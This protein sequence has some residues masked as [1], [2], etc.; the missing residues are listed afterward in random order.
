MHYCVCK[1][2][3]SLSYPRVQKLFR[4]SSVIT[5]SI[6]FTTTWKCTNKQFVAILPIDC[7]ERF[8]LDIQNQRSLRN[9]G[10]GFSASA[11]ALTSASASTLEKFHFVLQSLYFYLSKFLMEKT[12]MV[13]FF[14]NTLADLPGSFRNYFVQLF[15]RKPASAC[16]WRK[17]LH[18]RLCLRS[19]KNTQSWKLHFAGL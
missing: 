19:F 18:S 13:K 7:H 3:Y 12:S 16:F 6:I 10:I 11:S 8:D 14:S 17:E 1:D 4:V 2:I 15:C 9:L 5:K